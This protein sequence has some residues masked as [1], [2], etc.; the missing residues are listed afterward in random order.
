MARPVSLLARIGAVVV[1]ALLLASCTPEEAGRLR[2][3]QPISPKLMAEMQAKGMTKASPILVRVY[4]QEAELE[5][6]KQTNT[7]KFALLKTYPIC[8]WSGQ[9]G[10]KRVEGDRQV[11]EGFYSITA[12]AMNPNSRFYL[13]YDLGYPNAYDRALGRS[14]GD[15]MVHGAC[16]SRGCFSMTDQQMSEIYAVTREAFAGGQTNFQA[17]SFPFRM[18]PENFAK[19]RENPNIAFWK[20]LKVGYDHFELT[21]KPVDV[22]VCNGRYVFNGQ[23]G[24]ECNLQSDPALVAAVNAKEQS[25]AAAVAALVQAGKPAVAAIYQDGGIHPS[26]MSR[27]GNTPGR[28]RPYTPVRGPVLVTVDEAG[29]PVSHTD[30]TKAVEATRAAAETL[31]AA[32]AALAK[33]PYTANPKSI[34]ARQ[35]TVVTRVFG[36][37]VSLDAIVAAADKPKVVEQPV[38]ALAPEKPAAAEGSPTDAA[39]GDSVPFYVRL[40]SMGASAPAE[41]VPVDGPI[42]AAP[43]PP[44]RPK[45]AGTAVAAPEAVVDPAPVAAPAEDEPFYKRWL[46]LG[47]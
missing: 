5:I 29:R 13:S 11:P 12:S 30:A 44:A 41:A 46:G 18:T 22:A 42:V 2:G 7:G 38:L 19:H 39:A 27:L 4:K 45:S 17:Q 28:D 16:S 15:I 25:D 6:W 21:R 26:F 47:G 35:R 23:G 31:L 43:M 24:Q 3:F 37:G 1:T 32:E 20:M 9:L 14:G 34:E 8:R 10:P 40:L 33:R 36:D